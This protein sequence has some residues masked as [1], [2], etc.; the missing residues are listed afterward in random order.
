MNEYQNFR[1]ITDDVTMKSRSL[2][3]CTFFN[4][5]AENGLFLC[6]FQLN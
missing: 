5:Y 3:Y 4:N 2:S 6:G 1:G